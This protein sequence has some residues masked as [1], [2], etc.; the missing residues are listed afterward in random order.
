MRSWFQDSAM[1]SILRNT[2][3]L[4]LSKGTAAIASL[5]VLALA[6]RDLGPTG[7]GFLLLVHSYALAASTLTHFQSWQVIVRFQH[8][9]TISFE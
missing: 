1:R 5:A 8:D 7:V 2:S 9:R 3:L 6:A 4:G